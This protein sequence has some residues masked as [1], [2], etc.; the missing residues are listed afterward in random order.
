VA[1]IGYEESVNRVLEV[2]SMHPM[3]PSSPTS[4]SGSPEGNRAGRTCFP[5]A[6]DSPLWSARKVHVDMAID[7]EKFSP[8]FNQGDLVRIRHGQC[9]GRHGVVERVVVRRNEEARRAGKPGRTTYDVAI[10]D[11]VV[12]GVAAMNLEKSS[13][14]DVL[15]DQS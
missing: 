6:G 10:A 8:V 7:W 9:A 4:K 5:R 12:T 3:S 13:P 11:Q 2:Q 1:A 14:L 15:A